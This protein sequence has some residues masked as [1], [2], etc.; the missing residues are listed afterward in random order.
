[1][2]T[3]LPLRRRGRPRLKPSASNVVPSDEILAAAARL[4]TEFGY[5]KTSFTAIANAVGIQRAS[6][7]HYFP[8]KEALLL[9]IGAP[10]MRPLVDLIE[11]FDREDEP[12]DLQLY[13]YLRI[14]MRYI[15]SAPYDLVRIYQLPDLQNSAGLEPIWETIDVIH[16]AWV[17]W[18]RSGVETGFLRQV[19]PKLAGS[20]VESAYLGVLSSERPSLTADLD[21]TTDGFADLMLGGLV[22]DRA[23]LDDLRKLAIDRDGANPILHEILRV[24]PSRHSAKSA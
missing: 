9:E 22:A 8:N 20:L 24:D 4:F 7:Y 16:E 3:D 11:Q 17:R 12:G 23:R 14:D 1:M 6:L 10:W 13:R 21:K 19:E 15:G 2:S 18:I 5:E